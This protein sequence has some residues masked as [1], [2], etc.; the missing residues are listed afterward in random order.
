MRPE[1]D[2]VDT[3]IMSLAREFPERDLSSVP[4]LAR[5]GRVALLLGEFQ[6]RV[7]A[8]HGLTPTEYSL[9][10]ALR[11]AGRPRQL[12]PSDLSHAV[13][14]S[15]GG[16]TKMVDRLVR[17]GLVQRIENVDD[18]RSAFVRLTAAGA[19]LER[20][21]LESYLD[22][23]ERVLAPLSEAERAALGVGLERLHDGLEREV[24][25]DEPRRRHARAR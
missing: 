17:R 8:P 21:A 18:R 2:Q 3:F 19:A 6:K 25:T 22:G 14:C 15:P 9:L 13:E 7:L 11:R 4:P 16:L 20:R 5:L 1:P 12:R 10:G 23:A 24:E